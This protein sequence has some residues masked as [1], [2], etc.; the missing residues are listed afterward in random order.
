M[1]ESQHPFR[2]PKINTVGWEEREKLLQFRWEI[3]R[4][5]MHVL[6][7]V[8]KVLTCLQSH[9]NN[10]KKITNVK[11]VIM[12]WQLYIVRFNQISLYIYAA[13]KLL[14]SC[15]TLCDPIDGNPPGSPVPGILQARTLEWA[16]ISFSNGWNWKVKVMLLSRVWLRD[17]M[18]CSLPGSSIHGIFQTRVM[19][20]WP[21]LISS[22]A[23][24][25]C[26]RWLYLIL[27][28]I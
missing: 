17:P 2:V 9:H 22:L 1:Q 4:N 21:G 3:W 6:T 11:F 18:D 8:F 23:W 12:F 26:V 10:I 7:I 15:L 27:N 25:K 13:A 24:Y 5:M 14:Q 19:E 20:W 28:K 16:A